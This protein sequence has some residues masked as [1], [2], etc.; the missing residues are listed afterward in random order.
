[1]ADGRPDTSFHLGPPG[2]FIV[3]RPFLTL[4]LAG[5]TIA[6]LLT[7]G[8]PAAIDAVAGADALFAALKALGLTGLLLGLAGLFPPAGRWRLPLLGILLACALGASAIAPDPATRLAFSV[9][10]LIAIAVVW[11]GRYAGRA[12]ILMAIVGLV[13]AVA[14]C[15]ALVVWSGKNGAGWEPSGLGLVWL[16]LSL[17]VMASVYAAEGF[18]DRLAKRDGLRLAAA[19]TANRLARQL[20]CLVL[21]ATL[22]SLAGAVLGQP[23]MLPLSDG[24][25]GFGAM[26]L[27][28]AAFAG[29]VMVISLALLSLLPLPERISRS[30]DRS[31][32]AAGIVSARLLGRVRPV[33][34]GAILA[35]AGLLGAMML[36][37]RPDILAAGQAGNPMLAV[38]VLIALGAGL[39]AVLMVTTMSFRTSL[40][41]FVPL[42]LATI[43]FALI[44][45]N[46]V[47]T[48]LAGPVHLIIVFALLRQ[49]IV[50]RRE[51]EKRA[52]GK[53]LMVRAVAAGLPAGAVSVLAASFL[54]VCLAVLVPETGL[55]VTGIVMILGEAVLALG[56]GHCLGILLRSIVRASERQ[57]I[58]A[59]P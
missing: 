19:L 3:Q 4:L 6:V 15:V 7:S 12:A 25:Y 58:S 32:F 42:M 13:P 1:M 26:P 38:A 41:V 44:P 40:L 36:S 31:W 49:A 24:P 55:G 29:G 52:R 51:V 20:V 50:W 47:P 5:C 16:C 8:D 56:M 46:H 21:V 28:L 14:G 2:P 35:A 9:G 30:A 37:L 22:F 43:P 53:E 59:I 27:M 33:V 10:G 23:P 54:L 39:F 45:G 17:A 48:H 18:A 57:P 34:P 11:F